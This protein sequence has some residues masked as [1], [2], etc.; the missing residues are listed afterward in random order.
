MKESGPIELSSVL[1]LS[2]LVLKGFG[3]CVVCFNW[4]TD[5]CVGLG[6]RR[7]GGG[8][9]GRA[10]GVRRVHRVANE[11]NLSLHFWLKLLIEAGSAV[12][13]GKLSRD[14]LNLLSQIKSPTKGFLSLQAVVAFQE[15]GALHS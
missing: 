1:G 4:M 11:H 5:V 15:V 13:P 9:P 12:G 8:P 2:V 7:R 3:A 6:V 10:A 14:L